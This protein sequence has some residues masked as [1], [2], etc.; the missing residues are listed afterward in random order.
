METAI[1]QDVALRFQGFD[2]LVLHLEH[3][4][5]ASSS[6]SE[7]LEHQLSS[8]LLLEALRWELLCDAV[9]CFGEETY[10]IQFTV[11]GRNSFGS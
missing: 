7:H 5:K 6:T 2:R 10:P 3:A 8:D 4:V 11:F 1:C 9:C